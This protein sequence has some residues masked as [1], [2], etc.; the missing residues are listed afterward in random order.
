M[1]LAVRGCLSYFSGCYDQI[2][3]KIQYREGNV[4]FVLHFAGS[5]PSRQRKRGSRF[6]VVGDTG[7]HS[8]QAESRQETQAGHEPSCLPQWPAFSRE[9][10]LPKGSTRFQKSATSQGPAVQTWACRGTFNIQALGTLLGQKKAKCILQILWVD[11]FVASVCTGLTH[12][13][14]CWN[15]NKTFSS[16]SLFLG[17]L[18]DWLVFVCFVVIVVAVILTKAVSGL[19]I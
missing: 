3:D 18:V 19:N 13:L 8:R 7:L 15:S 10:L 17:C 4:N 11:W 6:E 5:S 16:H 14:H 9:V 2:P 1:N 12:N